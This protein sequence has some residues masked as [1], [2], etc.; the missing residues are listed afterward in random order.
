VKQH[1]WETA[2]AAVSKVREEASYREMETASVQAVQ[3]LT[4]PRG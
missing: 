1:A 3:S 2:V 4:L